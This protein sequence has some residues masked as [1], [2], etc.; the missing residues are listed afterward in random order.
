MRKKIKKATKHNTR[1]QSQVALVYSYKNST[2]GGEGN[3]ERVSL[4][5]LTQT[6][7]PTFHTYAYA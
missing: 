1:S 2:G 3:G 5:L 7:M 6:Y 4:A